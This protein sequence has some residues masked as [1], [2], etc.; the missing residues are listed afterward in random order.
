M[1]DARIALAL[2]T[3]DSWK[4]DE[5][6]Q[7]GAS[8]APFIDGLFVSYNGSS[9]RLPRWAKYFP[10]VP[11]EWGRFEWCDDFAAARNHSFSL[12][13]KNEFDW[14]MWLDTDDV[15]VGGENIQSVIDSLDPYTDGVMLKYDYAVEPTTGVVVVEQWRE[16]L[17]KL[18]S[19][20]KWR[21]S[22]HEVAYAGL[23]TQMAHRD[24]V[25]V[26]HLRK[27][28]EDRGARV[29]NRKILAR[30]IKSPD[31]DS[32]Y[33]FYYAA[34]AMSAMTETSDRAEFIARGEAAILAF[35][36]YMQRGEVNDDLY[37]ANLRVAEIQYQLGRFN[38][39]IDTNLQG[40]KLIPQWPDAYVGIAKAAMELSDWERMWSFA[41]I[42]L[43]M[44]AN[45][46]TGA[47][48]S[49]NA[50]FMPLLLRGIASHE[51]Q[52]Y[53]SALA[54]L[55]A[56]RDIWEPP[57]G[58]LG[59]RIAEIEDT[60]AEGKPTAKEL[61]KQLRGT[62]QDKSICFFTALIPDT[63]HPS[64][65]AERG[66]GGAETM[67][68]E[69]APRFA[70]EGWRTVVFGTPPKG[71][72]GV[73]EGVEYWNMQDFRHDE[74]F[75]VFVSSRSARVLDQP[76]AAPTKLLWLHDVNG[77]PGNPAKL[78]AHFVAL[79][80]WHAQ[81]L[82]T[83][84]GIE[85]DRMSVIPNGVDIGRWPDPRIDGRRSPKF[86]YASSYDRG[87]ETVVSLW[88]EIARFAPDAE[89]DI[90]YG[91]HFIDKAIE[92]NPDGTAGL[93]RL[94][95][96]IP[97]LI[98]Y[99]N[100]AGIGRVTEHGRVGPAALAE[101]HSAAS[102]WLYPTSFMETNCITAVEMQAA[103][104]LPLTSDLAALQE[105]VAVP[106]LRLDGWPLNVDYQ[107]RYL[108]QL[109][110]LLLDDKQT[111]KLRELSR[112]QGRAHAERYHWDAIFPR[113]LQLLERLGVKA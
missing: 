82:M 87:L 102:F 18:S 11:I 52:N 107:R 53:E 50:G 58:T 85:Q 67:I 59:K 15:L 80:S 86:I 64:T 3:G 105:T 19:D 94:R 30:E 14:V 90:Y 88:P 43:K 72:E 62:R 27:S 2:I 12:I 16:R 31:C 113:W 101:A 63:W 9:R 51:M 48:E 112:R 65:L 37:T 73:Y 78:D 108:T 46:S 21:Y 69:L 79:S 97:Q 26:R 28:G 35:R 33:L 106:W 103:G 75:T 71:S 4:K 99:Y 10:G 47:R 77:G 55:S 66:A 74:P 83:L 54:D 60:I 68:M 36:N 17:L 70:A 6:K 39:A 56:A 44:P 23:F 98:E 1:S 32:R 25:S 42:A 111:E 104:V 92:A 29:R 7:L 34:E 45:E 81:H 91:W 96:E 100:K 20:W 93:Q 84:Y 49:L 40:I 41:D 61:R 38:D 110:G 89:L 8:V 109:E 13:P 22:I 57:D 24:G 5:I 95:N 76:I